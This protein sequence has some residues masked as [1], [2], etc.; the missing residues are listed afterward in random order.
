M[1][2]TTSAATVTVGTDGYTTVELKA[3]GRFIAG[4]AMVAQFASL[5]K[6]ELCKRIAGAYDGTDSRARFYSYWRQF[7]FTSLQ[8]IAADICADDAARKADLKTAEA[9]GNIGTVYSGDSLF[10]A[11]YAFNDFQRLS[12]EGVGRSAGEDVTLFDNGEPIAEHNGAEG[13]E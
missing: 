7:A 5:S 1:N 11:R 9:H 13:Q 2:N 12:S 8:V 3:H 4:A 10:A 6:H